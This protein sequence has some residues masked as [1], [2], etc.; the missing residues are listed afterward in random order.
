MTEDAEPRHAVVGDAFDVEAGWVGHGR[1]LLTA[2]KQLCSCCEVAPL[3]DCGEER[4]MLD[5]P[6]GGSSRP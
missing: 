6:T 4:A 2:V 3:L 1:S 5:R